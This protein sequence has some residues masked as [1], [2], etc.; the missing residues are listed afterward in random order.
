MEN[1]L[2]IAPP[3]IQYV[4]ALNAMFEKDPAVKIVYDN[5]SVSVSLYVTGEAKANA[6]AGLLP[7]K[8]EFGN[9]TL[10][11]SV[12]PA[13][14][15]S[16]IK[17]FRDAFYGNE[18][19]NEIWTTQEAFGSNPLTYVIFAKEVV[20]YFNDNLGDANGNKSTLYENIARELFENHEG[21]YFCTD[22]LSYD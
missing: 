13:N 6:L 10:T 7:S 15:E 14:E 11:I 5:E 2:K 21:I 12:V 1:K 3:W 16:T 17:L 4:N 19:V 22:N 8:K 18:A 9:V 20:Q